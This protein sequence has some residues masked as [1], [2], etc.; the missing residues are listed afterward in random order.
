MV[1][2]VDEVLE[3][4]SDVRINDALKAGLAANNTEA[5]VKYICANKSI[6]N[7][8][9]TS[10]FNEALNEIWGS[11]IKDVNECRANDVVFGSLI[12]P[13]GNGVRASFPDL[14]DQYE[15]VRTADIARHWVWQNEVYPTE[16]NQSVPI[17]QL[18]N[19][20]DFI[21]FDHEWLEDK[22]VD[23]NSI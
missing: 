16:N 11:I 10:N 2:S 23:I 17:T 7:V 19:R 14:R 22:G 12:T 1:I 13:S 18:L 20:P 4:F 3:D 21:H 8:Y 15:N 9:A 6:K 5:I